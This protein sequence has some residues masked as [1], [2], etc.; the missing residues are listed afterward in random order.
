MKKKKIHINL[1]FQKCGLRPLKKCLIIRQTGK[2][3]PW[4]QLCKDKPLTLYIFTSFLSLVFW[5]SL[6]PLFLSSLYFL[7]LYIFFQSLSLAQHIYSMYLLFFF[8]S[9]FISLSLFLSFPFPFPSI[10]LPLL[11]FHS[12]FFLAIYIS[13]IIPINLSRSI[14]LFSFSPSCTFLAYNIWI[15]TLWKNN[16]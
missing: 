12:P 15:F 1:Q 10:Y 8:I 6:F 3:L 13:L 9:F 16:I 11:L 7:S 2:I 5:P 4:V 14:S